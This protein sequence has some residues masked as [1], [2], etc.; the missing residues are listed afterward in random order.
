MHLKERKYLSKQK[1]TALLC[2]QKPP[3][4]EIT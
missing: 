4:E 2:P 3:K 1:K